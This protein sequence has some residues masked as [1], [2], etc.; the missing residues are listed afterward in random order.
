L[1]GYVVIAFGT[2]ITFNHVVGQVSSVSAPSQ[3]IWGS[4]GAAISGLLGGMTAGFIAPK[5]PVWHAV[6]TW[7]LLALDTAAVI[8]T[9]TEPLW[10]DLAGS[11]LLAITALLGGF[12]VKLSRW[13][14]G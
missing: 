3:L 10:F 14:R 12:I 4:V 1:L 11:G 8:A 13:A 7:I 6:A 5:A 2:I 9:G